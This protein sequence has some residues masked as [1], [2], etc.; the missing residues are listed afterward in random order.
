[1]GANGVEELRWIL[2]CFGISVLVTNAHVTRGLR[3]RAQKLHAELGVLFSCAMCMAFWVGGAL[4]L[5]WQSPTGHIL[6]DA[7]YGSGTTFILWALMWAF[8]LR[9]QQPQAGGT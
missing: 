5:F 9:H 3:A 4:G 7:A 6:L 2:V 1:M 8:A